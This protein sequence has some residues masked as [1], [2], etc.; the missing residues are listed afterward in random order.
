MPARSCPAVYFHVT[1]Q[2]TYA[3]GVKSNVHLPIH[4]IQIKVSVA[5]RSDFHDLRSNE[6]VASMHAEKYSQH[7]CFRKNAL[8]TSEE[9]RVNKIHS[10]VVDS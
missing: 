3:Q 6:M 10:K 2:I 1:Y 5:P 8:C 4:N 9:Y 7:A